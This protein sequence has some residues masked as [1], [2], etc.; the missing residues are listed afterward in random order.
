MAK[1]PTTT[2]RIDLSVKEKA[3][4]VFDEIGIT[5]STAVNSFLKKVVAEGRIPVV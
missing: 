1:K 5:L 4:A 2:I 3:N